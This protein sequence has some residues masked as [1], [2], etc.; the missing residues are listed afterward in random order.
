MAFA[1][2]R[3]LRPL[4]VRS[5]VPLGVPRPRAGFSSI[6]TRGRSNATARSEP[7]LLWRE[8]E[9]VTGAAV[10]LGHGLRKSPHTKYVR[11]SVG[12]FT[13][14]IL[15]KSPHNAWLGDLFGDLSRIIADNSPQIRPWTV[16]WGLLRN[17][18]IA[19]MTAGL[20]DRRLPRPHP[21]PHPPSP[22][23]SS[24]PSASA[25]PSL[26]PRPRPIFRTAPPRPPPRPTA[27]TPRRAR[28]PPSRAA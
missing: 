16:T 15:G 25:S 21:R 17:P 6:A 2:V 1:P 19:P 3:P 13:G 27:A 11:R 5:R 14:P 7:A 28:A 24:S 10:G 18:R 4:P 23:P 20:H 12:G 22:S 9:R 26:V 8:K